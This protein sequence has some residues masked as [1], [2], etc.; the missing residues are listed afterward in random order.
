MKL[1]A[2]SFRLKFQGVTCE[3][4]ILSKVSEFLALVKLPTPTRKSVSFL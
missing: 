1:R 4:F 2:S 3:G